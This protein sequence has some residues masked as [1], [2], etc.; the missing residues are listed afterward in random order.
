MLQ[1][2]NVTT[3]WTQNTVAQKNLHYELQDKKLVKAQTPQSS[4]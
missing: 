1:Y 3:K 2:M 4:P